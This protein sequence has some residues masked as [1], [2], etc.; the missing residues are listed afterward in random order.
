MSFK[1][2]K[3]KDGSS[4]EPT[5]IPNACDIAWA[6]GFF[7]GE[8]CVYKS[9]PRRKSIVVLVAQ[10][11]PEVLFRL[12]I[13]FGGSIH[14]RN[15]SGAN[16]IGLY[17]WMVSGDRARHFMRS[18]W[19]HLSTRRKAKALEVEPYLF[20]ESVTTARPAPDNGKM[21]QSGLHGDMQKLAE[22]TSSFSN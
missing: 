11:D 17:A 14:L 1:N 2:G 21:I 5:M 18:V 20:S 7:E 13:W 16:K 3:A 8:G 6:A 19:N 15:N 12:K 9:N 4:L 10:K 22:T